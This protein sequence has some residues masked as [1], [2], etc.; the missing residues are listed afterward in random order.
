VSVNYYKR[1]QRRQQAHSPLGFCS[2]CLFCFFLFVFLLHSEYTPFA[3]LILIGN[4][5]A[6]YQMNNPLQANFHWAGSGFDQLVVEGSLVTIKHLRDTAHS[7]LARLEGVMKGLLFGLSLTPSK[8]EWE[9]AK[10]NERLNE[11]KQGFTGFVANDQLLKD[12][13]QNPDTLSKAL[14]VVLFCGYALLSHCFFV[15]LL[16][17]IY[18]DNS[19]KLWNT[20]H[21]SQYLMRCKEALTLF[22]YLLHATSGQ[23]ARSTE[24]ETLRVC[25]LAGSKRT[26]YINNGEPHT[27]AHTHTHT[28][29]RDSYTHTNFSCSP[30]LRSCVDTV[31][32]EYTYSKTQGVKL[33]TKPILRFLPHRVGQ[34][35]FRYLTTIRPLEV[36]FTKQVYNLQ[37]ALDCRTFLWFA[38][39]ERLD[40]DQLRSIFTATLAANRVVLSWSY[41]RH[42]IIAFMR[43]LTVSASVRA[44]LPVAEQSGHSL[45][46]EEEI[47]GRTDSEMS[48]DMV[49]RNFRAV[50]MALHEMLGFKY[51]FLFLFVFFFF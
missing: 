13:L 40:A 45:Q 22:V 10:E 42:V 6:V 44:F 38:N 26:L 2:F 29:G 23:P 32:L 8:A 28:R 3:Y 30:P 48:P 31:M 50:S 43:H 14:F 12:L 18:V 25:N 36:A 35:L 34:L 4:M 41:Y 20:H 46:T 1:H 24:F 16:L 17:E 21:A 47:Y 51:C 7:A 27:H 9:A 33:F 11:A 39:G 19:T 37:A 15:Y 5:A 49:M